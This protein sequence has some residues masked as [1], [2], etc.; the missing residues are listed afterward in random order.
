M[1]P[2]H[3]LCFVVMGFGLKTDFESGRTLDLDATYEAIIEPAVTAAGLRCVRADEIAHSGVIDAKMYEALYRADLVIADI[4]TGNVNAVYELGVRHAL[5]PYSTIIMKEQ[6]GRLHFD[7]NHVNLFQYRHL[8]Q[9]IGA[10]EAVRAHKALSNLIRSVM[11]AKIADSPVYQWLPKLNHP[12]F[13]DKEIHQFVDN[14]EIHERRLSAQIRA[15]KQASQASRHDD[16]AA[17][18]KAAHELNPDEPFLVQQW[19]LAVYKSKTPT[20]AAALA[21]GLEIIKLLRPDTSN[22]PETLGITGAIYKRLWLLNQERQDL[23]KAID[24]YRRGFEV[25]RDY[26]NGENLA[27]CLDLRSAIQSDQ[28]EA[29]YDRMTAAKIREVLIEIL[30]EVVES[31]SFVDRTDR[32]W[33]FATLANCYFALGNNRAGSKNEKLFREENPADW[34]VETYEAGKLAAVNICS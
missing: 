5:R 22:D 14:A 29:T 33:V 11:T 31:E 30:T 28:L 4:S 24:F 32:K 1:T 16:A 10:R 25:R 13:S 23:E 26:Y 6:D 18:F 17:A 21:Q 34:E 2:N 8:G 9:D 27:T 20:E 19:A 15:G 7:L 12:T 3:P